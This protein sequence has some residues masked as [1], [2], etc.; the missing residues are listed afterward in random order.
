M[1]AL[2]GIVMLI[3]LVLTRPFELNPDLQSFKLLHIAMGLAVSGGVMDV[4]MGKTK[5]R[6][7]PLTPLVLGFFIWCLVS[8]A[9]WEPGAAWSSVQPLLICVVL[10]LA[11]I[12]GV[13]DSKGLHVVAGTVLACVVFL[14]FVGAHQ[15]LSPSECLVIDETKNKEDAVS[16]GRSCNSDYDCYS[17]VEKNWDKRYFCEKV[18]LFKTTSIAHG[19]VRYVGKLHDP[20]EL[21]L[22]VA[23]A[24]PIAY[25]QRQEKKTLVRTLWA[26]LSTLII[27]LC[28]VFTGSRG[29]QLVVLAV[30]G[31]YF[32]VRAGIKGVLVAG[33]LAVPALLYG[34][35]GTAEASEST[36][37]RL[38]CWEAGSQMTLHF[39]VL[40]AGHGRFL[41]HHSQTAHSAYLLAGGEQGFPGLF[42]FLGIVWLAVKIPYTALKRYS[43]DEDPRR[44]WAVALLGLMGGLAVGILFLSM[45]YHEVFWLFMGVAGAYYSVLIRVDPGFKMK[46]GLRDAIAVMTISVV[47]VVVFYVYSRSKLG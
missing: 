45:S 39:P 3:C 18:G 13:V 9:R 29:A 7:T 23:C 15:G 43:D 10:C 20:N 32:L 27:L 21:G 42:M 19:R 22:T 11:M 28:V 26:V 2:P 24:L 33:A 34:G 40:G 8:R 38:E 1:L 31:T 5:F 14:A 46:V 6:M 30:F 44:A 41:E 12:H 47:M 4:L 35:R 36:M 16:D 25:A 17:T 37:R